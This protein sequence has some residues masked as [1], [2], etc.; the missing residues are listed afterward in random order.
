MQRQVTSIGSRVVR[1]RLTSIFPYM[2]KMLF[3]KEYRYQAGIDFNEESL[4]ILKCGK[5]NANYLYS[6]LYDNELCYLVANMEGV[7]LSQQP[8]LPKEKIDTT[9]TIEPLLESTIS[10]QEHVEK[11]RSNPF[12]RAIYHHWLVPGCHCVNILVFVALLSVGCSAAS[13]VLNIISKCG[14]YLK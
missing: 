11:Y 2:N 9:I 8:S 12:V 13:Y 7:V 6:S 10:T 1:K 5:T 4:V 3:M 14:N